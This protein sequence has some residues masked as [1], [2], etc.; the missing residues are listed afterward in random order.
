MFSNFENYKLILGLVFNLCFKPFC[1]QGLL[2]KGHAQYMRYFICFRLDLIVKVCLNDIF[3][4]VLV[5]SYAEDPE[6]QQ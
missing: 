6:L 5:V 1:C 3:K 4:A 2:F